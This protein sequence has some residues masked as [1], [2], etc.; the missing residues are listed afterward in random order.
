MKKITVELTENE[1]K[2]TASSLRDRTIHLNERINDDKTIGGKCKE[3]LINFQRDAE[4]AQD[5]IQKELDKL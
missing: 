4:D 5:K 1:A 2:I 3:W